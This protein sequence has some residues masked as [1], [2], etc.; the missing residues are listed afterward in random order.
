[1]SVDEKLVFLKKTK[2]PELNGK[3]FYSIPHD[4][5]MD[6]SVSIRLRK[7]NTENFP[8][9]A[10]ILAKEEDDYALNCHYLNNLLS[11]NLYPIFLKYDDENVSFEL[12]RT[13]PA[14]ILLPGGS[15]HLPPKAI[16]APPPTDGRIFDLRRYNVY[17][18][19]IDYSKKNKLPIFGICAGMQMI[20]IGLGGKLIGHINNVENPI[21][22][23]IEHKKDFIHKVN[24]ERGSLLR[25]IVGTDSMDVISR[26]NSKIV[27]KTE[28]NQNFKVS[29]RAPDGVIEA[30]EP[31]NPWSEFVLG[32]QWH[33]EAHADKD[34]I[35][36]EARIFDA[37]AKAIYNKNLEIK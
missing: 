31:I 11:R 35:G 3:L 8:L 28:F 7:K 16:D 18:N 4:Q 12:S 32:V 17:K 15:F 24:M 2:S 34:P 19:S 22:G 20:A 26:H 5:A 33:P 13:K 9:V 21:H 6:A 29:A 27:D 10:I 25:K 30:I 14:G 36:P 37:F 1:M 23:D